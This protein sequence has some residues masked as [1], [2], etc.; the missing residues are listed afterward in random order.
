MLAS[1][2]PTSLAREKMQFSTTIDRNTK[3]LQTFR[4][5]QIQY[6]M[7]LMVFYLS[8][9]FLSRSLLSH[10]IPKR[11]KKTKSKIQTPKPRSKSVS[12][13]GQT[14]KLR[15]ERLTIDFD[16]KIGLIASCFFFIFFLS[17]KLRCF[18]LC[19]SLGFP[20]HRKTLKNKNRESSP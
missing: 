5:S 20:S 15:P 3:L 4:R 13:L 17:S 16:E 18:F 2:N 8:I 7:L 9:L 10:H 19:G 11:P 12:A 6:C 14:Q 1:K